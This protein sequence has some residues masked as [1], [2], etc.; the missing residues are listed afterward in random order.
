[1]GVAGG[2]GALL[3][4]LGL[5]R[6][7]IIMIIMSMAS[8]ASCGN[9]LGVRPGARW[10][11]SSRK[12]MSNSSKRGHVAHARTAADSDRIA[13]PAHGGTEVRLRRAAIAAPAGSISW[14]A[15]FRE[16]WTVRGDAHGL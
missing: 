3:H 8:A 14:H 9:I 5:G 1:M 15:V 16:Q 10:G 6:P 4:R 7:T 11:R 2:G 12:P 13:E